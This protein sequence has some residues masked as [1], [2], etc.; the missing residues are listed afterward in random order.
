M[1]S[2]RRDRARWD[3]AISVF[4]TKVAWAQ[5]GPSTQRARLGTQNSKIDPPAAPAAEDR[6]NPHL[7]HACDISAVAELAR[8]LWRHKFSGTDYRIVSTVIAELAVRGADLPGMRRAWLGAVSEHAVRA[9]TRFHRLLPHLEDR[10][11]L[12]AIVPWLKLSPRGHGS[13]ASSSTPLGSAA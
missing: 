5:S 11:A 7:V 10:A 8:R 1:P 9:L 12:A 13:S 2:H 4:N 6:S 3:R